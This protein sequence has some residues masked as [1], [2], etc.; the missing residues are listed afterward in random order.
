MRSDTVDTYL[1]ELAARVPAPGGGAAGALHA[2]QGAAL[3]AM[4]AR[5]S[6]GPAE[7][8]QAPTVERVRESA[9]TLRERAL[10]LADQDVSA[11]RGVG[12][13]HRM[14]RSTPEEQDARTRAIAGALSEAGRVPA[15]VVAVASRV[16]DLAEQLRPLCN[17]NVVS[18]IAAAAE[19]AR[20]AA[21]TSR[22]NVEINLGAGADLPNRDELAGAVAATDA[23]LRRADETTEA[24]REQILR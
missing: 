12:R 4:V 8:E 23:V 11:F 5:Y 13:A 19:A 20:A 17:P 22:V 6:N 10:V 24:V 3:V 21:A 15:E 1:S 18:D 7:A 2:A 14:P 9:D 16:L